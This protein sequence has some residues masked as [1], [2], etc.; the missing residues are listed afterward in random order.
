M[1]SLS[2]NDSNIFLSEISVVP[3]STPKGLRKPQNI[4]TN[5]LDKFIYT[6]Y[7]HKLIKMR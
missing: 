7:N 3:Q 6:L 1:I 4:S 2:N 5:I